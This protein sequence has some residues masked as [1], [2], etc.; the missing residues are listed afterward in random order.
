ML[1]LSR[2][3]GESLIINDNIII[4]VLAIKGSQVRIGV[5]APIEIPVHREEIWQKIQ[6]EKDQEVN[7]D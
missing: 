3:Q 1:I 2:R 5:S 6:E 7:H 4:T